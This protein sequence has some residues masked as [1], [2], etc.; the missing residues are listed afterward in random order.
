MQESEQKII[1]L[2]GV[3]DGALEEL[4]NFAYCGKVSRGLCRAPKWWASRGLK[5]GWN[6]HLVFLLQVNVTEDTVLELLVAA[7]RLQMPQVVEQ[8]CEF[9]LHRMDSSNCL[10]SEALLLVGSNAWFLTFLLTH[11]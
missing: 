6:A 10:V 4:I 5:S 8:C 1:T 2:T 7:N 3:D 9:L 11:K